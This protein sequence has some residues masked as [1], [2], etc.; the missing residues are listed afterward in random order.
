MP[1]P[2]NYVEMCSL[3]SI[4]KG[5]MSESGFRGGYVQFSQMDED[6]I[7]ELEKAKELISES[8]NIGQLALG[9]MATPPTREEGCSEETIETYWDQR[10]QLVKGLRKNSEVV[11]E[12]LNDVRGVF[13][14]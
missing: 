7:K 6:V 10:T 4:S 3:H 2:Y 9:L 1:N 12:R 13:C 14:E 5:F 11:Y 8:N